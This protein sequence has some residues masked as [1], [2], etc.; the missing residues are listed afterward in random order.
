MG[1]RSAV[2]FHFR[3]NVAVLGRNVKVAEHRGTDPLSENATEDSRNTVE[4]GIAI[5][6]RIHKKRKLIRLPRLGYA[7]SWMKLEVNT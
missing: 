4:G 3:K 7:G 2:L 6:K 1:H 5:A